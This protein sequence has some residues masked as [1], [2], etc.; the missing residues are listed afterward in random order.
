LAANCEIGFQGQAGTRPLLVE[1]GW[2]RKNA[3]VV[4]RRGGGSTTVDLKPSN[5]QIPGA[6][7]RP[8]VLCCRFFFKKMDLN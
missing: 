7:N 5:L 2:H 1:Y 4:S 8:T 6:E 3:A